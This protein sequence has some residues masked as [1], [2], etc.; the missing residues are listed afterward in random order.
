MSNEQVEHINKW[1]F[2]SQKKIQQ[3]LED[4][5]VSKISRDNKETEY[6]DQYKTLRKNQNITY[7][8][9]LNYETINKLQQTRNISNENKKQPVFIKDEP[10]QHQL[11]KQQIPSDTTVYDKDYSQVQIKNKQQLRRSLLEN[12][13]EIRQKKQ[14]FAHKQQCGYDLYKEFLKG[15]QQQEGF[16]YKNYLKSHNLSPHRNPNQKLIYK[17]TYDQA[18]NQAEQK[19]LQVIK[20]QLP[21]KCKVFEGEKIQY[22]NYLKSGSCPRQSY[23]QIMAEKK[24]KTLQNEKRKQIKEQNKQEQQ[25]ETAK[26]QGRN[27]M[28]NLNFDR[29][30]EDI[31]KKITQKQKEEQEK[32][33]QIQLQEN[34]KNLELSVDLQDGENTSYNEMNQF[35]NTSSGQN[36]N[37]NLNN[38]NNIYSKTQNLI[39]TMQRQEKKAAENLKQKNQPKNKFQETL[40]RY[41]Q[42]KTTLEQDRRLLNERKKVREQE[43]QQRFS[44]FDELKKY[45]PNFAHRYLTPNE[46]NPQNYPNPQN[47]WIQQLPPAGKRVQRNYY[48]NSV[49]QPDFEVQN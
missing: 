16:L 19:N 44:Q 37:S 48:V 33:Q 49:L 24:Q 13:D 42:I 3:G 7:L 41:S 14:L 6:L 31:A 15:S 20:P 43:A 34:L 36:K 29:G 25:I 21:R 40:S 5:Y 28:K 47:I 32:L 8:D 45:D 10:L 11:Y 17:Q 22:Q 1:D 18:L 2:K 38:S 46:L 9:D 23:E 4:Q 26:K 27:F 30:E 35:N 39:N 12:R